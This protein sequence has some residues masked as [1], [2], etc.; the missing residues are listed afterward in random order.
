M[1]MRRKTETRRDEEEGGQEPEKVGY[2]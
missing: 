1:T 2:P